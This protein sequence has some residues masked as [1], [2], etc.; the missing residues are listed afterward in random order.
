MRERHEQVHNQPYV[1][2]GVG[3]S[4]PVTIINASIALYTFL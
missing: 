2:E 4:N 1:R 3:N